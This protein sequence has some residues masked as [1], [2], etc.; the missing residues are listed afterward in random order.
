MKSYD[1]NTGAVVT[2]PE[3]QDM[4]VPAAEVP[5]LQPVVNTNQNNTAAR[6]T[7]MEFSVEA[8]AEALLQKQ[9]KEETPA[10]KATMS[11]DELVVN[12]LMRKNAGDLTNV[13][14]AFDS[15]HG[16][17]DE[18]KDEENA[19]KI[20]SQF[21]D[22]YSDMDDPGYVFFSK[23]PLDVAN[24]IKE[25]AKSL[26]PSADVSFEDLHSED[27]GEIEKP[28]V[29]PAGEKDT[30]ASMEIPSGLANALFKDFGSLIAEKK[31]AGFAQARERR[32]G[33]YTLAASVQANE[34]DP[35]DETQMV[36][37]LV[38]DG[39]DP[40][41]AYT[42]SEN[43]ADVKPVGEESV[44]IDYPDHGMDDIQTVLTALAPIASKNDKDAK[45]TTAS[46]KGLP[47]LKTARSKKPHFS[48]VKTMSKRWHEIRKEIGAE[49]PFA[50]APE[51]KASSR[52][53]SDLR[54]KSQ[55]YKA[56]TEKNEPNEVGR[57]AKTQIPSRL[58]GNVE[59]GMTEYPDYGG[60]SF[61]DAQ[62]E[63]VDRREHFQNQD[64][65]R[66]DRMK[67]EEVQEYDDGSY[68]DKSYGLSETSRGDDFE[69]PEMQFEASLDYM[70]SE[71]LSKNA[72]APEEGDIQERPIVHKDIKRA[73]G[74]PDY[75]EP[76]TIE[77]ASG[78]VKEGITKLRKVEDEIKS[79]KEE[80]QKAIAPIQKQLQD[81]QKPFNEALIKKQESLSSYLEMIYSQLSDTEN[82]IAAYKDKIFAV[83]ERSKDVHK[84]VSMAQLL[85]KLKETDTALFDAVTKVKEAMENET[86]T[87][88]LERFLYEYPVSAEHEKKKVVRK[89]ADEDSTFNQAIK[90]LKDALMGLFNVSD[91]LDD[92][93][94]GEENLE[95]A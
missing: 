24:Q 67:R 36:F 61:Q 69:N 83:V 66:R 42:L 22:Y 43:G 35:D 15:H 11:D 85:K 87:S 18:Y 48:H 30:T 7:A 4:A 40:E 26:D 86:V 25:Y 9:A 10:V 14:V 17:A 57:D 81:T 65:L 92:D 19:D 39:D 16:K 70:A 34:E 75:K 13:Y 5:N 3:G 59:I 68:K 95:V 58:K 21:K 89:S 84:N 78:K 44:V 94:T 90:I 37:Y 54:L 49:R 51:N 46:Q 47:I 52:E 74:L 32:F 31:S 20:Q 73:P 45:D 80:L 33:S 60:K 79:I 55:S 50:H 91:V 38:L 82:K 72:M 2:S 27:E 12:A 93:I 8:M 62:R 53:Q 41:I 6:K 77:E 23:I 1:P 76:E 63:M 56:S 29:N 28:D 88:V 71:L 64:K